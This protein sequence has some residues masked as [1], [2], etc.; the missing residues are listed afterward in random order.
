MLLTTAGASETPTRTEPEFSDRTL[1]GFNMADGRTYVIAVSKT[2][3]KIYSITFVPK[4][5][6]FS[7]S[8]NFQD[9][10]EIELKKDSQ[11]S[12][13]GYPPQGVGSPEP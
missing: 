13:P 3:E 5:N 1:Y 10:K 7:S 4:P 8:I 9:V 2:D 11:Q 12:V 6:Y